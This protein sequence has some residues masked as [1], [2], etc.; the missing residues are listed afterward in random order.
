MF[1]TKCG[2]KL[3]EG[4][5]FCSKC[6]HPG[7]G[8]EEKSEEAKKEE[9]APPKAAVPAAPA[10]KKN[11][12]LTCA[13]LFLIFILA[14]IILYL[15]FGSK[16]STSS[17]A[18][19]VWVA[20]TAVTVFL[21][22]LIYEFIKAIVK[23]QVAGAIAM[24]VAI[25]LIL[26]A[27]T[28]IYYYQK[29]KEASSYGNMQDAF[30]S[31]LAAEYLGDDIVAG[32]STADFAGVKTQ[33]A[34]ATD[35]L[36]KVSPPSGFSDYYNAIYD[37]SKKLNDAAASKKAWKT[38]PEAPTTFASQVSGYQAKDAFQTSLDR[39]VSTKDYGDLAIAKGDKD[40]MRYIGAEL[41]AEDIALGDISTAYVVSV[42][43][44]AEIIVT[45]AEAKN[46]L[47]FPLGRCGDFAPCHG[48]VKKKLPPTWQS[49]H[50]YSVGDGDARTAWNNAWDD[51]LKTISIDNGYNTGGA[52]ITQGSDPKAVSPMEQAF[53]DECAA[54][55][56]KTGGAS[57][58]KDRLPTTLS[59]GWNCNYP[60]G[61]QTCWDY[62][63]TSGQRFMGGNNGC[64][65]QGLLPKPYTAPTWIPN[66]GGGGNNGGGG[67]ITPTWNGNYH[68]TYS[69][70]SCNLGTSLGYGSMFNAAGFSDT[71]VV[72]GNKV[73][74]FDG[75]TSQID[76]AGN[77]T[78]VYSMN[79]GGVGGI[80][81]TAIYHFSGSSVSGKISMVVNAYTE[82]GTGTVTCSET[83]SGSK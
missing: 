28:I 39:I 48:N 82:G 70:M 9:P 63:T 77:A 79:Y 45:P 40:S 71:V 61:S 66:F 7:H 8:S 43:R 21:L 17:S 10:R 83:F 19:F 32:K 64:P 20:I 6:G 36:S 68:V 65:E 74:N 49:A 26:G 69:T 41:Q 76:S 52:G 62:L 4:E 44:L 81:F 12:C 24:G 51:M 11:P 15:G 38:R 78:F 67:T 2:E 33:T 50:R 23:K 5:K 73:K 37:W 18:V 75:T 22:Y 35:S 30:T 54:K 56:G 80:K 25:L 59:A 1:C 53:N 46:S 58:V 14:P 42:D 34:A 29:D 13:G 57:G 16:S 60:N 55:G 72:S 47:R 3:K 31:A 27:G